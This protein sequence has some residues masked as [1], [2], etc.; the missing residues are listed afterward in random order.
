MR[1]TLNGAFM[2]NLHHSPLK[3]PSDTNLSLMMNEFNPKNDENNY[4]QIT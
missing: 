2:N 3:L 1:L 4:P